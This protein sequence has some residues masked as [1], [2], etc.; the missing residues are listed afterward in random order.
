[1]YCSFKSLIEGKSSP[2]LFLFY[3]NLSGLRSRGGM[4]DGGLGIREETKFNN[5]GN[6]GSDDSDN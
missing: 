4:N 2:L 3:A 1:M 5:G 6:S